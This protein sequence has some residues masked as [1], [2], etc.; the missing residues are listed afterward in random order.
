MKRHEL[1]TILVASDLSDGS[2]LA[3]RSAAA[4]ADG[5]GIGL[6]LFHCVARPVFPYW[7][8]T[9]S[10]AT[11]RKWIE[12]ARLDLEWQARR[13]LGDQ[14]PIVELAVEL[15]APS[16]EITRHAGDI[17]AD[18]IILGQHRHRGTLGDLLGTTSDRVL[19]TTDTPVLVANKPL[20]SPIRTV[21]IATDFSKHAR[22]ALETVVDWFA[23]PLAAARESRDS[24]V[25]LEVLY[26]AAF[27]SKLYRPFAIEPMLAKEVE[28]A[29]TRLPEDSRLGIHPR[30]TSAPHPVD[31]ISR[32]VEE[33]GPDLV[34]LGT[35]GYGF[36]ARALLGSVASS[37]ART[38][39]LPLLFVPRHA[40]PPDE[41]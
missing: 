18:V 39:R 9:V 33:V 34:V 38:L 4:L 13:V 28:A 31:G 22:R 6:S 36:L 26:V 37:I 40:D 1:R 19:R 30:V 3:L 10:P 2:D 8:G 24:P 11:R 35:H 14:A 7:E 12:N 27:A 41:E 23:G 32:A 16:E 17:S 5:A 20:G 21:L 15:G 25:V 29:R